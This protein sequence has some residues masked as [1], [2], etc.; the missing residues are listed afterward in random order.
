MRTRAKLR[1]LTM[2]M[3]LATELLEERG[4]GA[5]LRKLLRRGSE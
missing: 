3:E 1:E 5:E 2:R 4:H